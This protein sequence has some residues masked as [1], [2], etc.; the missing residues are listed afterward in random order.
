LGIDW[1]GGSGIP[2][3]R[4]HEKTIPAVVRKREHP[5]RYGP[6]K[7]LN[8][9]LVGRR[10]RRNQRGNKPSKCTGCKIERGT[11][12]AAGRYVVARVLPE[13]IERKPEKK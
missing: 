6:G 12:G 4:N 11:V 1:E 7:N 2:P 5:S 10:Q 3:T 13:R 9:D 8:T